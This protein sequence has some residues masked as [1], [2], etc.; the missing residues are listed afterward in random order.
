MCLTHDDLHKVYL[1]YLELVFAESL[2][3]PPFS[4]QSLEIS[5]NVCRCSSSTEKTQDTPMSWAPDA[6]EGV[7]AGRWWRWAKVPVSALVARGCF[8]LN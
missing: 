7:L 2:A 8:S 4:F 3:F 6:P 1:N 5:P